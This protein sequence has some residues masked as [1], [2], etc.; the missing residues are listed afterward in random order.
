MPKSDREKFEQDY[1]DW[2]RLMS[3]DAAYR[4][5]ALPDKK[6]KTVLKAYDDFKEP[7]AIFRQISDADRVKRLAGERI[8]NFIVIETDA[9][10]FFP[11][12]Y[13]SIPGSSDFAV[14]MN[15]RLFFQGLWFPIISLNSEYIRKSSDRLLTFA[16]EHEFEMNR[17]YQEIS[18]RLRILNP[19]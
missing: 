16:L 11:S 4:L 3:R 2:I 8:S 15:R 13:S 17:I 12:V 5:S 7:L 19:R 18:S 10:T 14:A 1:R 6:Q 9:I